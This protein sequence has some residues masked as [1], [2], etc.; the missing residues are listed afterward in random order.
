MVALETGQHPLLSARLQRAGLK[1]LPWLQEARGRG[2]RSH[3]PSPVA[4]PPSPARPSLL[5]QRLLLGVRGAVAGAAE[6]RL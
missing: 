1:W 6:V 3:A 5:L 2:A 4:P